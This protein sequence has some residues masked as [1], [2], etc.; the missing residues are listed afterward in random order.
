[1]PKLINEIEKHL[2]FVD[3]TKEEI[4]ADIEELFVKLN[5]KSFIKTPG[6]TVDI[7]IMAIT[8]RLIKKYIKPIYKESQRYAKNVSKS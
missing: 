7:L 2:N 5:V 3:K 8:E 1:M 6:Q 4:K